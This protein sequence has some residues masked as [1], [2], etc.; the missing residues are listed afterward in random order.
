[1]KRILIISIIIAVIGGILID[2]S[3][4]KVTGILMITIGA[5]GA[6][7][8]PLIKDFIDEN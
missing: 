1:M 4:A 8:F 5:I 6:I 3:Q 2:F 7:T